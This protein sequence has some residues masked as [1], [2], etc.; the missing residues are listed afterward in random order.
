MKRQQIKMKSIFT[1]FLFVSTLFCLP[2]EGRAQENES[3]FSASEPI[4]IKLSFSI[5]ELKQ[6]ESDT[7]YFPSVLHYKTQGSDWDS[8]EVLVRARGNSRRTRCDFPP[9]RIK[10]EEEVSRNTL[11]EGEKALKLVVPCEEFNSYL[12]LVRKE[13]LIYKFYEE[14]T[15]YHFKTTSV[16]LGLTD[17]SKRKPK[18]YE[19][20]AFLIEDDDKTAERFGGQ[21]TDLRIIRPDLFNDTA[22]LKQD[23]FA[24]MVGNTDWS[25]TTQHNVKVMEREDQKLVAIPYDFDQAGFVDAPYAKPY[26]RLPIES[27]KERLY[28]GV[29]QD[30]ELLAFV[31]SIFLSK[32]SKIMGLIEGLN[33]EIPKGQVK[34]AERF[35]S[36]FFE[37]LK[38]DEEL[39]KQIIDN[40]VPYSLGQED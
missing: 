9:I 21:I 31:K 14:I 26:D 2:N 40:C 22:S 39:Q 20:P 15:P 27:T 33:D 24:F 35:I 32:E 23:I 3:L 16:N 17:E 34:E 6:S 11:F 37:I 36:K 19:L 25:N 8:L 18:T 4:E 29:C 30:P 10:I 13:Y 38:D 7:V 1:F 12:A 28:L 5:E